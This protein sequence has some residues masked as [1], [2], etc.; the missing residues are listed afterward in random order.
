MYAI[1]NGYTLIN[2][3]FKKIN[4]LRTF[5]MS[6]PQAQSA[7]VISRVSNIYL[8]MYVQIFLKSLL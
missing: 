2:A 5:T 7:S 1:S 3:S 6:K 8:V 4:Q